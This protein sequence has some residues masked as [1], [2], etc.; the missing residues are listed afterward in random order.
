MKSRKLYFVLFNIGILSIIPAYTYIYFRESIL[1]PYLIGASLFLLLAYVL[2]LYFT[3]SRISGLV[4]RTVLLFSTTYVLLEITAWLLLSFGIIRPDMRFFFHGL[5]ATN[6][7][8]VNYSPI[9]GY[10]PIPGSVRFVS[11]CNGHAEIDHLIKANKMGWFSERDYSYRKKSKRIKRYMVLGDSFSSGEVVPTTWVDQ[12]QRFLVDGGNDSVELYN[13]SL[14]GSGIQNWY[15]IFFKELV[16]NYEFDGII[17]APSAERD[18]VPDFDRKFIIAQSM[19]TKSYISMLDI[20]QQ[21]PPGEFPMTNAIPIVSIYPSEELDRIKSHYESTSKSSYRFRMYHP[22]LNFL[23]ILC[24]ISDGVYKLIG[25]SKKFAA[26]NK[27]YK[28]YCRLSSDPYKMEYFDSRYKYAYMLKEILQYCRE[29]NKK[30]IVAGIPDYQQSLE[31]LKGEKCIYR[32]ELRFLAERYGAG[33]FDGFEIFRGQNENF[34]K[35]CFY[36]RDLHW[37]EKGAN[38]FATAFSKDKLF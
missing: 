18:G 9:C 37:N 31:F 4:Q 10:Q 15:R 30:I 33:Y 34:I 28:D 29:S 6:N 1:A 22:D 8:L 3:Q 5:G 27:P 24:G 26:Y 11:I 32:N 13:F 12:V 21:E 17:I 23:A 38:L 2:S 20:T 36:K 25:F 16:P 19:N 14:D 7:K 35:S